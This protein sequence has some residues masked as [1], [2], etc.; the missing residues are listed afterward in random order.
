[1]DSVA[2]FRN[3]TISEPRVF[4]PQQ[5]SIQTA[6]GR[7]PVT[8]MNSVNQNRTATTNIIAPPVPPRPYSNAQPLA[9]YN[10]PLGM[11]GSTGMYSNSMYGSYSPY[12][13]GMNPYGM[14]RYGGMYGNGMYGNQMRDPLDPETRFIQLAEETSRPAFQ[15]IE[16]LVMAIGNIASMLDST[17]FA[18][19]SSFRAILGVA[20]N[21]GQLRGVFAQFW[22]TFALIRGVTWLYRKLLYSLGFTKVDPSTARFNEIFSASGNRTEQLANSPNG[23]S[24]KKVSAWPILTFLSL[25]FATPYLIMKLIGQVSTTAIEESRNPQTWVN[26]FVGH[27]VYNYKAT[28]PHELSIYSGQLIQLAPREVQQTHKLLNTG[29]ALATVD[30]K[31]SGLVPINYVQRV[32]SKTFVAQ[33]NESEIVPEVLPDNLMEKT[34][35]SNVDEKNSQLDISKMPPNLNKLKNNED[36]HMDPMI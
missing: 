4:G 14:N 1:M 2:N 3:V 22:S 25:I 10:S 6:L 16:S 26:P 19:T 28:N 7:V 36:V 32:E 21:I 30:N 8:S 17:F 23:A 27:V 20:A 12:S 18:L 29:W 9:M 13:Y 33:T 34:V 31:T 5:P 11:Y 35:K 24:L 15:S